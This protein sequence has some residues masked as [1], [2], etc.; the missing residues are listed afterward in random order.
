MKRRDF[1]RSLSYITGGI[2]VTSYTI[3]SNISVNKPICIGISTDI[4][5][6]IMPDADERLKVFLNTAQMRKVD[7]VI[8]L[9]DFCFTKKENNGFIDIWNSSPLKKYNVLGNHDMDTGTKKD[10]M[11]FTGM[12]KPYYS[13]DIG[14]LHFIVLDPNNLYVDGEY[15]PYANAN[16]YRPARHRGFVDPQQLE[17]L[18]QD[19][20]KTEKQCIVFSHQNLEE[21]EGCNN[22]DLVREI[23]AEANKKAEFQKVIAAFNGHHHVDGSKQLD[24]IQYVHINSMSYVWVG[25]KYQCAERYSDEIN[26]KYPSLKNTIPFKEPLFAIVTISKGQILIEG[27]SSSFINPNPGELGMND[28]EAN[29]YTPIISNK[30]LKTAT[31][32]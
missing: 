9:G 8:D 10:F 16:F 1:V 25:E 6:D 28:T 22:S 31:N 29:T 24:D 27:V 13:F 12:K 5:K 2:A 21:P 19:L 14:D 26:K 3:A 4:H 23:F 7:F 15:I 32:Y 18:K 30:K 17:W 20:T 11:Q